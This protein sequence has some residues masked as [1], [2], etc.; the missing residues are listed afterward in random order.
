VV[1]ELEGPGGAI[2]GVAWCPRDPRRLA[3]TCS[4]GEVLEWDAEAAEVWGQQCGRRCWTVDH[5]WGCQMGP[6][7]H[8][9]VGCILHEIGPRASH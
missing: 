1:G 2:W 4:D 8:P 7:T 3:A 9:N 6:T 5:V